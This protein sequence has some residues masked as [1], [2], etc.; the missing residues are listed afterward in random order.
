MAEFV[1][2]NNYFE[3]DSKVKEQISGTAIGTKF[4]PPYVC[5]F[6]DKVERE[7]LEDTKL[8]VWLRYIDIFFIWTEGENKLESFLQRLITFHPNLKFTHE[9]SKTSINFLDAM[10]SFNS[11]KFETNLYSKPTDCHQFLELNSAHPIHIKKSIVYSKGLCIKRL[12]LS[13]LAFE[14]HLDSIHSWF[15]N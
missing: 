8:W 3:F 10:V 15:G 7:I 12:C 13:S 6:M 1:L 11:D 9:K 5:I 14:N 4:A 2:N